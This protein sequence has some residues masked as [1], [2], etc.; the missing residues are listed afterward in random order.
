[1]KFV[2]QLLQNDAIAVGFQQFLLQLRH[3]QKEAVDPSSQ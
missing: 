3:S 1:M 2:K